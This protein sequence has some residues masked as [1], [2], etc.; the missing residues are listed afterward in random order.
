MSIVTAQEV[1]IIAYSYRRNQRFYSQFVSGD[2][3][4]WAGTRANRML[5]TQNVPSGLRNCALISSTAISGSKVPPNG[6]ILVQVSRANKPCEGAIGYHSHTLGFQMSIM[7][8][9]SARIYLEDIGEIEVE[10]G[11]AWYQPS[12]IKHEVLEYS[13]DFETIEITLPAEFPTHDETW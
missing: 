9:G 11:D 5:Y 8:K 6:E 7:I 12:G 2:I 13:D 10:A 1:D 3:P 4:L